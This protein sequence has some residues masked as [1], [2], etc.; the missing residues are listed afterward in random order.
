MVSADIG[1]A[2]KANPLANM[3]TTKA[4]RDNGAAGNKR[5]Q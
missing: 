1:C 3:V 4:R 5:A 2:D